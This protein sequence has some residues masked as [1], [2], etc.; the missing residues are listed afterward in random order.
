LQGLADESRLLSPALLRITHW[1]ADYYLAPLAQVIESVVPAGVRAQAGTR[2]TTFYRVTPQEPDGAAAPP[3]LPKKQAD[4]LAWLAGRDEPAT[5]REIS[6]AV[7]CQQGPIAALVRKGLLAAETRRVGREAAEAPVSDR[8]AHLVLNAEQQTALDAILDALR[9]GR[10]ETLLLLGITG[11]G[12]TEVYIHA[13][14]EVVHFG[15]Q[16]IVLVPEISLTPQ[17]RARFE[18]RFGRVA[19][20][21]SHMSDVERH[22]QW[23][24][25]ARGEVPVI[26]GAR[27]AVFAPTP[28]LGLIVL[29]E[30]HESSFKQETSPRYHARDVALQRA[31]AEGV[32]LVLGSAT[33]SLESFRKALAGEY[34]LLRL[35]GRVLGR[36]LPD[37][38]TV[39]LRTEARSRSMRGALCRPLAMALEQALRDGGQAILLLNRRG[40]A[41]HVQCPACGEVLRCPECDIAL[42][43]HRQQ[44]SVLCHYCD[45]RA[46]VPTACPQCRYGAIRF[47][48]LGTERLEA[49]VRARFPEVRVLRMDRDSMQRPGSHERALA[50]FRAGEAQ[51]LLGTQMIAKGLDFPNVTLVGVINA[52]IALHLPDF[53]AGERTLQ[54]LVQVAGRTGRGERGGRVLV[55]TLSPEHPAVA[56]AVRHDYERFARHEL[57]VRDALAYPPA[58]AMIR[59]VVRGPRAEVTRGFAEHVAE[60]IAA[61]LG[62]AAEATRLL[63]PAPAPIA[64]IRG[65]HRFH[66]QVQ[67]PHLDVLRT[68]VRT[69]TTDLAPP[70]DVQWIVDVDPLEMM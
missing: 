31:A 51:V 48:G 40:F 35:G 25:I 5:V 55:Q 66:L 21:H 44:A 32:P 30:E 34:R 14:Q 45:Y 15:R 58:G 4:V 43:H 6:A 12:K 53:R 67:G 39:D 8:E 23:E 7:G 2:L 11:S 57:A 52:D 1:I 36:P 46:D 20:L 61:A 59:L 13:I 3:K 65:L 19:V 42:T 18:A 22:R 24:R 49:E 33:P 29:D 16:A 60:R 9:A 38:A 17:T 10:H 28:H 70:E 68:A 37:V 47:S 63:G 56:C 41:T 26:V 54:L 69:A 27:S 50:A 64:R 62:P